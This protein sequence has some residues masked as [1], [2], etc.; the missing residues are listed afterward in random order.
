MKPILYLLPIVLFSSCLTGAQVGEKRIV[1][2]ASNECD[3][4]KPPFLGSALLFER[5]GKTYALTSDHVV[6]HGREGYCHSVS[7]SAIGSAPAK[8]LAADWGNGLALLEVPELPPAPELP[9]LTDLQGGEGQAMD[10]VQV[11][12][13]PADSEM[14][15]HDQRGRIFDP[16]KERKLFALI[17]SLIEL[18]NAHGEF[19]MSGGPV[20]HQ[21]GLFLGV[22]SHQV[23][24]P[25][26]HGEE[27]AEELT[28]ESLSPDNHLVI[29]PAQVAYAWVSEYFRDPVGFKVIFHQGPGAQQTKLL[30]FSSGSLFY[31]A[32]CKKDAG[33][34]ISVELYEP[35]AKWTKA[36]RD[37]VGN[38]ERIEAY[39]RSH[40]EVNNLS[41]G[42]FRKGPH[43]HELGSVRVE[44]MISFFRL[45]E[46]PSLSPRGVASTNYFSD[47]KAEVNEA[48]KKLRPH[49]DAISYLYQHQAPKE[50]ESLMNWLIRLENLFA[51]DWYLRKGDLD[52]IL[53][54]KGLGWGQLEAAH[55]RLHDETRE[56]LGKIGLLT[57]RI[58]F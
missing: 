43:F 49:Y 45:L 26:E 28:P 51:G 12:G 35:A 3:S 8:F 25:N 4:E 29:I 1:K 9:S 6:L 41:I 58:Y 33:C 23:L 37:S 27:T 32:Y 2:L 13:F 47:K 44:N 15:V 48:A 38:L 52:G 34:D 56:T 5:A 18:E 17:P 36:Y 57:D 10:R 54:D 21:N 46:D 30:Q 31:V 24:V 50:I 16:K 55:K 53:N 19:G 22:L 40:K 20:F 7:N 11:M 39:L 14:L 42:S